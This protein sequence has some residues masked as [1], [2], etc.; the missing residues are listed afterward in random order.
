MI[1]H[2]SADGWLSAGGRRFRCVVGRS[3]IVTDKREGDGGTPAGRYPL[4]EAWYRSDRVDPPRTGLPIRVI[5][6]RDG[7]CDAP[8]DPAYNR[9][10]RLPYSASA[11]NLWRDDHLYDLF[12]VIGY[13]DAPPVAGVGSAIFLHVAPPQGRPTAGCV[14]LA[15]QDLR[16]VVERLQPGDD[17]VISLPGEV[18]P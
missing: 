15:M 5:D 11:E 4:R 7:W 10:V 13:N 1:L 12:V 14:A 8:G 6:K 17:I 3:G 2:V 18:A 16:D 9:A